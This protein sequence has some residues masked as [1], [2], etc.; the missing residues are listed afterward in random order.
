MVNYIIMIKRRHLILTI[1]TVFFFFSF[2]N[3]QENK[4]TVKLLI[5]QSPACGRCFQVK[6]SLLP[7]IEK[8]YRGKIILEYRDL[9]D[10]ENYR[11]LIGLKEKHGSDVELS[12]PVFFMQGSFLNGNSDLKSTL[13][14]F[15]DTNLISPGHKLNGIGI[16]FIAYFKGIKPLVIIGSGLID[17][18]NPCAFTVIVFF[19]SYLALQGYRKRELTV[20]AL[21]FIAAVF[22]I[23]TLIGLGIFN[24]LYRMKAFWFFAKAFNVAVGVLSILLG[25][26]ALY[27]FFK[28]KE[29][30]DTR[31]LILQL[32]KVIKE[33]IHSIIGL[34]YR[35]VKNGEA[36]GRAALL[37]LV[38]GALITG[39]LVSLLEAV[40]TGQL[41]LPTIAFVLKTTPLKLQAFLYLIIYNIM[42][43]LPL[44]AI[45]IMALIGITS[46]QFAVFLKRRL[47]AMKITMALVFFGLGIFLLWRG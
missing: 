45:F 47:G 34:R 33:R 25:F 41:Y 28:F 13:P 5:F 20:I 38:L 3:A 10:I 22:I 23:Y 9:T 6:Q 19:I 26:F 7:K 18:I 32:P 31:D 16:D 14:I 21:S 29:T 44:L 30:K 12:L 46:N 27:D 8:E 11:L 39:F 36:V 1:F 2:A 43:I 24:F 17:G 35:R 37:R 42:F 4:D 40:C 15:I